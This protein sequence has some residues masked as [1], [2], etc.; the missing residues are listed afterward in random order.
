MGEIYVPTR[1]LQEG[2]AWSITPW[3]RC[4]SDRQSALGATSSEGNSIRTHCEVE[5][6]RVRQE[7]GQG[8][9][10]SGEN[11][12]GAHGLQK[13]RSQAT[14]GIAQG[15]A[16]A[17]EPSSARAG[18]G[19][20]CGEAAGQRRLLADVEDW[21]GGALTQPRA[22]SQAAPPMLPP[23]GV[24]GSSC[25]KPGPVL[26]SEVSAR[27]AGRTWGAAWQVSLDLRGLPGAPQ[28]ALLLAPQGKVRV[29][30][31]CPLTARGAAC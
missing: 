10:G 25:L 28:A 20:A 11:E 19:T 12:E 22:G 2:V 13:G 9:G 3:F 23:A 7:G 4:R 31:S 14:G 16:A 26:V 24:Q 18:L 15:A 17:P 30:T 27:A 8:A 21:P 29:L 1:V 6:V 5:P